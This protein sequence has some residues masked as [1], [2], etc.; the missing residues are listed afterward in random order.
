MIL[1]HL[2][3]LSYR[4]WNITAFVKVTTESFMKSRMSD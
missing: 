2:E 1:G 3:V 4:E